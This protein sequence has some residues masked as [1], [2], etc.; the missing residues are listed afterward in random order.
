MLYIVV[1]CGPEVA[2][3]S[4]VVVYHLRLTP[5]QL[6]SASG[7]AGGS[8]FLNVSVITS[9]A[10]VMKLMTSCDFSMKLQCFKRI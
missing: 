10:T 6:P 8:Q 5:P 4:M 9:S 7:V 3:H 1:V 2:A